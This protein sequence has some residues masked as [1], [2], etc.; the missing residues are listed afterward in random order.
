MKTIAAQW[1]L[2]LG[3]GSAALSLTSAASAHSEEAAP[4]PTFQRDRGAGLPT[5][6]F[7]TYIH[8]GELLVYPFVEYYSDNNAEYKP[9]ELGHTLDQDF[10]GKYRAT[11]GLLFLAYGVSDRLALEV[12]AAMISADLETSPDDPS[13]VPDKISESGIGDVEGQV[14]WRW[15]PES[16]SRP[17][18]FSYFEAVAPS[19][20][21][22]VLIGTAAWEFKLG[23]GIVKGHTWGTT[24][25]RA[26]IEYSE[27]E[28]KFDLGEYA[29]EYFKRLSDPWRVYLGVEGT[30]DE[31][32]GITELQWHFSRNAA[33]KLNNAVGLTSKATDWAPEIGIMFRFD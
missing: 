22:K 27:E 3:L 29:L 26:A 20:K 18:F 28:S 12:E 10:R 14:R 24:T 16:E 1:I 6:M 19:Q 25:F 13:S 8:P 31:V 33:I 17:E 9:E 30:Q 23:S 32:E 4:P 2:V 7:G 21:H 15:S 5:S 11:E